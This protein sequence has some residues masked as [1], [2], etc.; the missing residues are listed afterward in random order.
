M[1]LFKQFFILFFILVMGQVNRSHAEIRLPFLISDG[2]VLQ[3]NTAINVWGWSDTGEEIQIEFNAAKLT[4]ST[5]ENGQWEFS[6]PAMKAGG[7][8]QMRIS[9]KTEHIEINDIWVGDVYLFSGQSNMETTMERVSPMFP[10]EFTNISNANI[11][12]FD[13]P[14]AYSFTEVKSNLKGGKWLVLNQEN[15]RS[16]AAVSYFFAKNLNEKYDVPIGMVNASVGGSPI[17]SWLRE[18]DLKQFPKDYAEALHFQTRGVIEEIEKTDQEKMN[19]WRNE[20]SAKDLGLKDPNLPWYSMDFEPKDWELM[21][22]VDFWPLENNRPVNGVFWFRKEITLDFD[23]S[24]GAT[25]PLLLGTLVDSDQAYVNGVLVG[26]TGYRYPPRRY[27]IPEGILK[28]GKNTLVIRIVNESGR[29]GFTAEKPYQLKIDD[30]VIDLS[31]SWQYK[32]GAK[33]PQSPSQTAVRFK[34][35]GLYNAMIAPLHKLS[36]KGILWYQ[37]ESNA[38]QATIYEQQMA[39]LIHGWREEWARPELPFLFVQLPNFMEVVDQPQESDWAEMREIQ[40]KTLKI[41]HTGM[42]ITIDVGEANDIHPLDK[43]SVGDRLALQAQEIIY[44]EQ[45]GP[46]SGPLL[47]NLNVKRNRLILKFSETG[48]GLTTSDGKTLTGFA[49]ADELGAFTW[50][51]AIHKKDKVIIKIK[52]AKNPTKLRYAWAN[53]PQWANL[54]NS[55]GLPASPF[56]VTLK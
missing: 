15:I 18:E 46:F 25:H 12:Y 10:D 50:I 19:F 37:G 6:L 39:S 14:D 45:S 52:G 33:M 51:D 20:L 29:G 49:I 16:F 1:T 32:I 56:E 2:M 54:I 23:P 22:K 53:N 21:E 13:V 5:G 26:S 47:E 48:A 3:R 4:G 28:K 11:R 27:S 35:M 42:A 38:G 55:I 44:G 24:T 30:Q 36:L 31:T 41:P 40:R 17:Q 8:Y 43:K 34:P 9:S 7:P